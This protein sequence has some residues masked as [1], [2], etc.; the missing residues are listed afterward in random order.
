[1]RVKVQGGGSYVL[2]GITF[3]GDKSFWKKGKL[4]P[5]YIGP[6][7]ILQQIGTVAY[8]IALPPKLSHIHDIFHI[9]MLR[10]YIHDPMHVINHYPLDVS[11]DL[12]Y[13]EK[14][15][16]ILDYRDQVLRNKAIP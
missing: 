8:R 3:Q 1:M 10:K 12:S 13:I 14:L 9:L 4:N 5:R 16:E 11:E 6:I 7:E 2:E 15:I